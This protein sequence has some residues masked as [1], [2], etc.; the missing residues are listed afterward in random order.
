MKTRFQA[1]FTVLL[2]SFVCHAQQKFTPGYIVM[3]EG[4]TVRGEVKVN[5]KK[6]QEHYAKVMF[7]DDKGF[8]RT[9][10]PNKIKA[11]GFDGNHYIAISENEEP[12]FYRV[13]TR[14]HI[15]LLELKYEG[16]R[17]NKVSL[18][19]EYFLQ[20]NGEKFLQPVK[21]RNFRKQLSSV[22][23]DNEEIA[24][25]YPDE[26][27][28]EEEAALSAINAYNAWKSGDRKE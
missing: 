21:E 27:Q 5:E 25:Q 19:S 16:L 9:W 2:I 10:K 8:Q 20:V 13:V 12:S 26:K 7:K 14:G 18:E 1:V 6:P 17:M 22:M 24:G 15:S 3:P 4:D 11:Y 28:F 23:S